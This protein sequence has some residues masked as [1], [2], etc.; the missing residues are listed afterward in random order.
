MIWQLRFEANDGESRIL[1]VGDDVLPT[2]TNAPPDAWLTALDEH[3]LIGFG[4]GHASLVA[5]D[6]LHTALPR[7]TT[8]ADFLR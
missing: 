8:H 5:P 7:G 6:G 3:L 1:D 2:Q 4:P